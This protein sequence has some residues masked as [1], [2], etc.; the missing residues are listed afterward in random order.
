MDGRIQY[1]DANS[2]K[3]H[4]EGLPSYASADWG[5]RDSS[6]KDVARKI[7]CRIMENSQ[8]IVILYTNIYLWIVRSLTHTQSFLKQVTLVAGKSQTAPEQRVVQ[9]GIRPKVLVR[10]AEKG[11]HR[12]HSLTKVGEILRGHGGIRQP[13][14]AYRRGFI[15][16]AGSGSIICGFDDISDL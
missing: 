1:R 11:K 3:R 4:P 13:G 12:W 10:N 5:I 15:I 14:K 6:I 16:P 9:R 2:H 8:R 7:P